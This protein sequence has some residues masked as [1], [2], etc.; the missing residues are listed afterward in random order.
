DGLSDPETDTG[1]AMYAACDVSS[2]NY[3][4]DTT[5]LRTTGAKTFTLGAQAFADLT[6][7]RDAGT[8]FSVAVMMDDETGTDTFAGIDRF[9]QGSSMALHVTCANGGGDTGGGN[10]DDRDG[11]GGVS[12]VSC[13]CTSAGPDSFVW[14]AGAA[15]VMVLRRRR[16]VRS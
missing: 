9:D 15:L 10:G 1:S 16:E 11:G 8:S 12:K 7:A 2:D 3:V 4:S 6:A 5:D 13:G 14:L